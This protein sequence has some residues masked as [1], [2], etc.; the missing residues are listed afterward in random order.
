MSL[1]VARIGKA[2]KGGLSA[3]RGAWI[4]EHLKLEMGFGDV[5]GSESTSKEILDTDRGCWLSA[6]PP[7]MK[8]ICTTNATRP[9]SGYPWEFVR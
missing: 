2:L 7:G 8:S 3:T 4:T 1:G 9:R 6:G 5:P